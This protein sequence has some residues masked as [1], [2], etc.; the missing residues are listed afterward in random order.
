M[1]VFNISKNQLN[2]LPDAIGYLSNLEELDASYNQIQQLTSCISYLEKLKTLSLA[3]NQIHSLSPTTISGLVNLISLDLT[4]N[5]IRVLPAE[6][7]Q[8]QFLRRMRL[9]DCPF[10][11][12]Q[13][14]QQEQQS[15]IEYALWHDPPSLLEV[16]GRSIKRRG[17]V[18][19]TE[20][21]P[22]HLQNYL[23]S[24]KSCT[25]CHGP[26]FESCVLRGR[27]ME[28]TDLHIPL[29]YSLCSAHW[30]TNNDRIQSMFSSQPTTSSHNTLYRP[31]LPCL[32][33]LLTTTV[34]E[35]KNET[36]RLSSMTAA[37]SSLRNKRSVPPTP[38]ALQQSMD[39]G[40]STIA[41]TTVG[42]INVTYDDINETILFVPT[43]TT[44]NGAVS[45]TPTSTVTSKLF[46]RS[47]SNS[48]KSNL[49]MNLT[50]RL[51]KRAAW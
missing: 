30:S 10:I 43:T 15:I 24:A 46:S 34:M 7:S 29:E 9:E 49:V 2:C 36:S 37:A 42:T 14:Q 11:V 8:L 1:E 4:Q 16:C 39:N 22:Q 20:L 19:K 27:L 41:T 32:P 17:K 26:Y 25:S 23:Q 44:T 21:L 18:I 48:G 13:Q 50:T 35:T 6:I 5:P 47:S 33:K 40:N 3:Y 31:N 38:A 45:S 51:K 12:R 28:K